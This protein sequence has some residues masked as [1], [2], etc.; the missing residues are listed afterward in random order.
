MIT[1]R[2]ELRLPRSAR[3][4]RFGLYPSSAAA[5]MIRSR[6][7]GR[8]GTRDSR[9]L[10]IRETVVIETPERRATSRRVIVAPAVFA[11]SCPSR[12]LDTGDYRS[13]CAKPSRLI[14]KP[15]L[16]IGWRRA[17]GGAVDGLRRGDTVLIDR[18][19][20]AR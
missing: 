17:Y 10:R 20:T 12:P 9:P 14:V 2:S 18:G 3:A 16:S 4:S 5:A 19:W 7:A 15:R 8:T 11:T 13:S 1:P 6:V